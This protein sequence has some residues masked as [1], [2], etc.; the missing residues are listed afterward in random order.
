[1]SL[2][3]LGFIHW[4]RNAREVDAT[5]TFRIDDL[6][7][8][9]QF[10]SILDALNR[11]EVDVPS[12]STSLPASILLSSAYTIP[13]AFGAGRPLHLTVAVREGLNGTLGNSTIPRVAA[14]AECNVASYFTFRLGTCVGGGYPLMVSG[15]IGLIMNSL[16]INLATM[17]LE[18]LFTRSFSHVSVAMSSRF[19]F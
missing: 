14:G 2:T 5:E 17:N 16:T 12:F 10:D 6:T 15:G 1:M 4:N 11:H 7:S 18:S 9:Q 3:D 8:D 13:R 19:E